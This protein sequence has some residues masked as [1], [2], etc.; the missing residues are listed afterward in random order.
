MITGLFLLILSGLS[1]VIFA[2]RQM[3]KLDRGVVAIKT[4]TDVLI[5]WR[6]FGNEYFHASYN[7]YRGSTK[8]N[9]SPITG[10]SYYVDP[11]KIYDSTYAVTAILNGIEQPAS[12]PVTLWEYNYKDIPLQIPAG[13]TTPDGITCTYS[14]NDCSVGDLDGDGQYEIVLKWDPSNSKD[15][16]QS[17]YTGNVYLD[18]YKLNGTKLWRI[19]LGINIRAGA[20]YTQFMVYD[21]DGDGKAEI[22]CKTAPGTRDATGNYLNLGP[23]NGADHAADYRNSSGYIL[24]GPEYFTIFDGETGIELATADYD[25]PRGSLASW[26]DTYGNRVDRFLACITYLDGIRPS[27]VMCR[28][29]YTGNNGTRGRTVLAAWD[30]RDSVLTSR[31]TFNADVT[32]ENASYTGQGNHNISVADVDDDG[33]DEIIYGACAIDD[34]GTGLWTT[35]LGHGDAMHVSDI[36]PDRPGLEKWGIH[37]GSTT[38]G[39]ALLNART[40]EVIWKTSNAD[41]GRGVSADLTASFPGMECWGGTSGLRSCKNEY[42]GESPSSSNHVIWWD[43]DDQRELLDG[44]SITKYNG[45]VQLSA[46][47]CIHN[48][49][50]KSN[51][52]LQADILGDWH[53]EVIFRRTENTALRIFVTKAGTFRRMY[54]LMHDPVYRLGIAWQ[55]VAYNQPPH[56]GFY[57]GEGIAAPPPPISSGRLK[58]NAGTTWDINTSKNWIKNDTADFYNDGDD[59]L[60][61]LSGS[62][63]GPIEL[64]GILNPFSVTVYSPTDYIF[65]GTGFL[66]GS[67][68]LDKAG[69]GTLTINTDN[70]YTGETAVWQGE[71]IMNGILSASQVF[72]NRF[73]GIGGKGTFGKGVSMP[74]GGKVTVS[75]Q[76]EADTLIIND[77]LYIGSDARIYFDLTDDTSGLLKTND[78]LRITGDLILSGKTTIKINMLDGKL[79]V[80]KYKLIECP[81]DFIGNVDDISMEG[82]LGVLYEIIKT[83]STL[84]LESIYSPSAT[85]IRKLETERFAHIYPNPADDHVIIHFSELADRVV[86]ELTDLSGIVIS[87]FIEINPT[88]TL[89]DLSDVAPGFYMIRIHSDNHTCIRKIIKN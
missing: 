49:G 41:V 25:P 32:G 59:V 9:S 1:D 15:N 7:V 11:D 72:V 66:S 39:S 37:E 31:W 64:N 29:Y 14:A 82:L 87:S 89:L 85:I 45:A 26:G 53:E 61:D 44:E 6:I 12:T 81:G 60:F 58:W 65:N 38:P 69:S 33:K 18:A 43:G 21:L 62:N 19:D 51:P 23:A 48:N 35:G 78:I 20:H 73:S 27:V 74:Y 10:P 46:T 42:T 5:S 80:G 22:A 76:G 54:T 34:D 52:C 2:Q 63:S 13:V 71:L 8:I 24:S 4:G 68:R 84:I 40:G 36:D 3:E 83:D 17:G 70:E 88:R 77:S 50:S 86:I 55:N 47:G 79:G 56:T 30:Y 57:L 28:G 67:M 16:S 75:M